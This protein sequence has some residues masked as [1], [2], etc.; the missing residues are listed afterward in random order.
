MITVFSLPVCPKCKLLKAYLAANKIPYQEGS[1][2]DAEV[3]AEMRCSGFFG[4]S[5]PVISVTE[6]YIGPEEFF[7]GGQLNVEKLRRLL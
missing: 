5:A 1:L 7:D 4:M 6:G 3:I 2:E